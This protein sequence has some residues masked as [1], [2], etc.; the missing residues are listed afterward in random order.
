MTSLRASEA[1]AHVHIKRFFML[2][3]K[4]SNM[5]AFNDSL[6]S[7]IALTLV[8]APNVVGRRFKQEELENKILRVI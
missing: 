8:D 5:A 7:L 1:T 4:A 6:K 2:A 3:I